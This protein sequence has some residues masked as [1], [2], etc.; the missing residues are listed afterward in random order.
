MGRQKADRKEHLFP[1]DRAMQGD[2]RQAALGRTRQGDDLP[3]PGG[4]T[5]SDERIGDVIP[6]LPADVDEENRRLA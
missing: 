3:S 2:V 6:F 1:V 5:K 4:T